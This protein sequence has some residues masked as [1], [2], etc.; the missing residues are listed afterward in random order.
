MKKDAVRTC[1]L[2]DRYNLHRCSH[3]LVEV[4]AGIML[5]QPHKNEQLKSEPLHQGVSQQCA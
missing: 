3:D 5:A 2:D 1:D 4:A